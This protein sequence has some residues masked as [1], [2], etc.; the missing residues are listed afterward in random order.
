MARS[1]KKFGLG[2]LAFAAIGT[3]ASAVSAT[4][5]P[6]GTRQT[7]ISPDGTITI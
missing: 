4:T 5:Y 7:V 6:D 2:M 3:V 1:L